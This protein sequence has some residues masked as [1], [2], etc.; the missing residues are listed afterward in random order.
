MD[1]EA[2][3]GTKVILHAPDAGWP[4]D[5]RTIKEHGLRQG[6]KYTVDHTEPHSFHTYLYLREFP[7][8]SFNTVNFCEAA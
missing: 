6:A 4:H 7:C 5:Q 1:I 3:S 2:A 8:V